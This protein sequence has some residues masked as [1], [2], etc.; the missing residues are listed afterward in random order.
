MTVDDCTKIIELLKKER[1]D[2]RKLYHLRIKDL[3]EERVLNHRLNDDISMKN[4]EINDLKSRI[5]E[6]EKLVRE[7]NS[8]I[9]QLCSNQPWERSSKTANSPYQPAGPEIAVQPLVQTSQIPSTW[10]KIPTEN[11][12]ESLEKSDNKLNEQKNK[13]E[14]RA[15]EQQLLNVREQQSKL[16]KHKKFVESKSKS[17]TTR[18]ENFLQIKTGQ[19]KSETIIDEQ[20]SN[21]KRKTEATQSTKNGSLAKNDVY[22]AGD[23]MLYNIE[24]ERL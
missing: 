3:E 11:R 13:S 19:K 9:E 8:E 21:S 24:A 23:L 15:G 5:I 17:K 6:L 1:E 10:P 2:K 22:L 14:N 16:Y 7:R 18:K 12:S 4:A 20:E